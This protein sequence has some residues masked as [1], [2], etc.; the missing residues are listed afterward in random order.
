MGVE[1]IPKKRT[2]FKGAIL[3]TVLAVM[4]VMIIL[5]MITLTLAGVAS[6]RAYNTWFDNQSEYTA[7]S[8]VDGVIESFRPGQ[9]NEDVGKSVISSLNSTG[10]TVT[11]DVKSN[12]SSYVP[13]Y[14]EIK[15][16]KF[17]YVGDNGTG[18]GDYLLSGASSLTGEKII[19]VSAMVE[20]G[21]QTSTYSQYVIGNVDNL[22]VDANG[23][24]YNAIGSNTGGAGS[25]DTP[26]VL[27]NS[28]AGINVDFYNTTKL[29]TLGNLT[30]NSGD[31]F[32][33]SALKLN[34][35]AKLYLGRNDPAHNSYSGLRVAGDLIFENN[36]LEVFSQY[37]PLD[38]NDKIY[39]IPYIYTNGKLSS[40]SNMVKTNGPINFYCD[41]FEFANTV[42]ISGKEMNLICFA[43]DTSNSTINLVNTSELLDWAA[44]QTGLVVDDPKV[45]S[46]GNI[47]TEG[48][49]TLTNVEELKINGNLY[50][51]GKLIV[52]GVEVDGT[53]FS[54]TPA[55]PAPPAPPATPE[56]GTDPPTPPAPATSK[57]QVEG[58][59]FVNGE[60][61]KGEEA[62]LVP[63]LSDVFGAT[64]EVVSKN[65]KND[66]VY[67]HMTD[68]GVSMFQ[69]LDNVRKT[70]F[71]DGS[72]IGT[73][74]T[75][76]N[77]NTKVY[78]DTD[79]ADANI[80][81]DESCE[82]QMAKIE[83]KTIEIKP[84]GQ[85]LWIDLNGIG[86]INR[87]NIIVDDTHGGSV[88]FFVKATDA[89]GKIVF[90]NTKIV[91]STYNT[92]LGGGKQLNM[93]I[94][95]YPASKYVPHIY[96]YAPSTLDVNF[97]FYNGNNL[98]TGDIIAP[99]A[100]S[101]FSANATPE[102]SITGSYTM[103]TYIMGVSGPEKINHI[104]VP[105]TDQKVT[106]IGSIEV[107]NMTEVDNMFG[108]IYVDDP[109]FDTGDGAL[110]DTYSWTVLEGYSNGTF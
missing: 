31:V 30:I 88:K 17:E 70:F 47:Y 66:N 109:P 20:M 68:A 53:Y 5:I 33:N 90:E 51:K 58:S 108:Y 8:L 4:F 107:T 96:M 82:W 3:Y 74:E 34:T 16:L 97:E 26:T 59:I 21:G 46:T 64:E 41:S 7:Q 105:L 72:Y 25:D 13:G 103:N 98:F 36:N 50:V 37:E 65:D 32:Y 6:N 83:D 54:G 73:V 62:T 2:R 95:K 93:D 35:G 71:K 1:N 85:E 61:I 43:K 86:H 10:A 28:Y 11:L 94:E 100:G 18:T 23:G 63:S 87:T 80:V 76:G 67:E 57:I 9:P 29:S 45:I 42:G 40:L 56:D 79:F 38:E 48:D 49:L 102:Y 89:T 44:S 15:Q 92:E 39:N 69:S 14:G 91:T 78:K 75:S 60:W 27:G 81:I 106:V 12:G 84:N 52:D 101:S 99:S 55:P 24:G 110:P 19:K 104:R 22:Y 77:V